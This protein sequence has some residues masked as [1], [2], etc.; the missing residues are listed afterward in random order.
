MIPSLRPGVFMTIRCTTWCHLPGTRVLA[1]SG[2]VSVSEPIATGTDTF[3]LFDEIDALVNDVGLSPLEA[4][5]S[6]T[7]VGAAVIGV[8]EDFGSIEVGKVADLVVY[9]ADPSADISV[10][11]RPSHVIR[12]GQLV[13]PRE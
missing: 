13:R 3:L 9:P 4:I 1:P 5:A 8:D 12:G 10:L 7:S 6:A 11:R 2:P